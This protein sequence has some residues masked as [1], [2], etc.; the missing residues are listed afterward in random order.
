MTILKH[1]R[2][3][4]IG[5]G[6]VT[7]AKS[8]PAFQQADGSS[9]VAVMRRDAALAA[10]YARRHQVPRWYADAGSLL[11]DPEVDAVYIATPP[12]SHA[13]LT[14]QALTVGK[15]VYVEKPMGRSHSECQAMAAAAAAQDLPLFVAYYRRRLP[16][17]LQVEDIL[18]RGLLGTVRLVNCQL[19]QP[20]PKLSGDR[21][22]WRLQPELSGGGLLFDV[23]SHQ[24]D[25]LDYLFGP[26]VRITGRATNQDRQYRAE[27]LACAHFEFATG[28]LGSC[29]WCFAAG[30]GQYRDR[31]E[32]VG[33]A[34]RL[35]FAVFAADP[36]VLERPGAAPEEFAVPRTETV[37]LPLVQTIVD[38]LRGQGQCPST[39]TTAARTSWVL[40]QIVSG[41]YRR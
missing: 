33:S 36:I 10:D 19:W 6:A 24:L 41:Y 14:V 40:D 18:R 39:G 12:G 8:G 22:P 5:C 23:G 29:S 4:I 3:G 15:P 26:I 32:I 9:L 11:A 35:S 20:A 1:V 7:E 27:D 2:W 16:Q 21:L 37:Q 30:A 38:Q 17:F 25:L 28:V 34:G 31:V 13:A